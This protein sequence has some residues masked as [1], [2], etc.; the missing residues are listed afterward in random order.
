M[1]ATRDGA[2]KLTQLTQLT[3]VTSVRVHRKC[4]RGARWRD[5]TPCA[6]V[7]CFARRGKE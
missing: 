2:S 7:I 5:K 6:C 3:L 1:V 4:E